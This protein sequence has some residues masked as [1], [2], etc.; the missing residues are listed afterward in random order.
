[1]CQLD[2]RARVT[3]ALG[4]RFLE[5]ETDDGHG[6]LFGDRGLDECFCEDSAPF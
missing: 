3:V 1:M 4:T 6:T 5:V 2:T